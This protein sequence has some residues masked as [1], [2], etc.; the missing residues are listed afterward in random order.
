MP[1]NPLETMTDQQRFHAAFLALLA[2]EDRAEFAERLVLRLSGVS[3][4]EH[5]KRVVFDREEFATFM[6][7]DGAVIP[8]APELD[9]L[10]TPALQIQ[11]SVAK[12]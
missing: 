4:A 6:Q 8:V 12:F 11:Y 9:V 2:M 5:R 10:L 1:A 3:V 7:D